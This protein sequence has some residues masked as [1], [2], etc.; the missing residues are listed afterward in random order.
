MEEI[1]RPP[2]GPARSGCVR[3]RRGVARSRKTGAYYAVQDFGRPHSQAI[4]FRITNQADT[5]VNFTLDGQSQSIQPGYTITLTRC[6]PPA[7]RFARPGQGA[8]SRPEGEFHSRGGTHYVIARD[9]QGR[10]TVEAD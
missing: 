4:V 7:V 3:T 2:Q 8:G 9:G 1:A 5:K 6:R 10:L